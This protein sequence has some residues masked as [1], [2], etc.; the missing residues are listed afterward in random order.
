MKTTIMLRGIFLLI[1]LLTAESF[2]GLWPSKT[3]TTGLLAG[4]SFLAVIGFLIVKDENK[5]RHEADLHEELPDPPNTKD[6]F[7]DTQLISN[8]ADLVEKTE[9]AI[10]Q[11]PVP[12][13]M[14][15]RETVEAIENY[16][17]HFYDRYKGFYGEVQLIPVEASDIQAQNIRRQLVEMGIHALSFARAA[18]LSKLTRPNDEPNIRLILEQID[19][20]E[21]PKSTYRMY[22]DDPYKTEKRYH[23]LRRIFQEMDLDHLN[24]LIE[25]VCI[26]PEFLKKY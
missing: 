15:D 11:L 6:I 22:T 1:L 18:K 8:S 20:G 21:L 4:I 19:V 3:V 5:I 7:A 14:N 13:K 16:L 2:S 17:K 24:V 9:S 23:I 10:Q 25:T 12:E 26:S